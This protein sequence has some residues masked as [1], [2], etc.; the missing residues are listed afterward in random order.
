MAD[1]F[2]HLAEVVELLR[3]QRLQRIGALQPPQHFRIEIHGER[4][5]VLVLREQHGFLRAREQVIRA[6]HGGDRRI[7]D[8]EIADRQAVVGAIDVRQVL[9]QAGEDAGR[10]QRTAADLCFPGHGR[11]QWLLRLT[12][13]GIGTTPFCRSSFSA[14]LLPVLSQ[15]S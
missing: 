13:F 7:G 15:T 8:Q 2:E 10:L 5:A 9:L 4:E 3:P 14:R 6:E 12:A 11:G 1:P